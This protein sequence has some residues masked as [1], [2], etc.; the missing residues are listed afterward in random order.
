[1]NNYPSYVKDII[2]VY[3]YNEKTNSAHFVSGFVVESNDT[4]EEAFGKALAEAEAEHKVHSIREHIKV[5][6]NKNKTHK[7]Q[8]NDAGF[9]WVEKTAND[10]MISMDTIWVNGTFLRL[11]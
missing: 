1:M 4:Y 8:D 3:L 10:L 7:Q 9:T 6:I 5:C 11:D 2:V